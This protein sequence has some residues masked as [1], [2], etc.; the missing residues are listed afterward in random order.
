MLN[1]TDLGDVS[2]ILFKLQNSD[3]D[4]YLT[5][6][7]FFNNHRENS[8]YDFFVEDSPGVRQFLKSLGFSKLNNSAYLDDNTV[9]VYRY[10]PKSGYYI[11]IDIQIVVDAVKKQSIQN[12]MKYNDFILTGDKT[13][14]KTVWNTLMSI[15]DAGKSSNMTSSRS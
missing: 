5:G 7:R 10:M 2:S 12:I 15:Y 6:S 13:Y 4:F 14:A 1:N 11:T 3:L 8:D 9:V